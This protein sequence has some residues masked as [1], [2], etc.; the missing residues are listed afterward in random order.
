MIQVVIRN[1]DI[2]IQRHLS[3]GNAI[4][5]SKCSKELYRSFVMNQR[6]YSNVIRLTREANVIGTSD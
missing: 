3:Y 4:K 5:Y 6:S 1:N 2:E